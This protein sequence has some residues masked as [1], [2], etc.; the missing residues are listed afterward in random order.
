MPRVS[1]EAA[2]L[3]ETGPTMSAR[4]P[5]HPDP[6]SPIDARIA[7][8]EAE[9]AARDLFIAT[10]GHELRN[11]MVPVVLAVDRLKRLLDQGAAERVPDCVATLTAATDAFMR[12][13]TQLLDITRLAGPAPAL[14]CSAVPLAPLLRDAVLRHRETARRAGCDLSL[15]EAAVSAW[16]EREAIEQILDNLLLNAFKYGAGRPVQLRATASRQTAAIHVRDHGIGIA[17]EAQAHIFD[18]FDRGHKPDAPGLGIGLF[19]AARLAAAMDGTIRLQSE[20][21]QGAEF[22]LELRTGNDP[23]PA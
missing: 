6:A 5:E 9:L 14:D 8:L 3:I 17:S 10:I 7:E 23:A 16:G 13:A 11:P 2:T 21:G 15:A 20:P 18:L 12:R 1:A 22:R 4:S 19:I